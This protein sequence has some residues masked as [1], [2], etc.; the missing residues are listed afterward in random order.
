[1]VRLNVGFDIGDNRNDNY[2]S[3]QTLVGAAR[4]GVGDIDQTQNFDHVVEGTVRY[5]EVFNAHQISLLAGVEVQK[6]KSSGMNMHAEGFPADGT[7]TDNMALGNPE[8]FTLGSSRTRNS[9][10]SA[11][12]RANYTFKDRYLLTATIRADGSTR[13]GT[14]NKFGYFPSFAFAWHLGKEPFMEQ[15]AFVDELKPRIS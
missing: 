1:S 9:L 14:N 3:R 11:F 4:G 10:A 12:G 8:T 5:N 2:I 15:V 7:G 13:F 6:F